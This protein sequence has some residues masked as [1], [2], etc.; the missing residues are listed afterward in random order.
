V[1]G[2]HLDL[3][4]VAIAASDASEH[5]AWLATFLAADSPASNTRTR[6]LL[7]WQPIHIGLLYDLEQG[8]YFHNETDALKLG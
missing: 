6:E 2:R 3:P 4:V 1:I 7:G 8:H 5:F